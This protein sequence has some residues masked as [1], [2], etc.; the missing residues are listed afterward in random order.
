MITTY[1]TVVRYNNG[2]HAKF[3]HSDYDRAVATA[4]SLGNLPTARKIWINKIVTEQTAYVW[5]K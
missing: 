3:P 4:K 1:V 5:E 2:D